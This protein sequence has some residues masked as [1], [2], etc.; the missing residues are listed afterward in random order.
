MIIAGSDAS[1]LHYGINSFFQL[2]DASSD[3]RSAA[4][5]RIIDAP[6]FP[7]RWFYYSTNIYVGNNIITAKNIWKQASDFRL[8]GVAIADSKFSRPTTLYPKYNDSLQSLKRFSADNY[9]K[10][11]P[12]IMPFGYSGGLLFHDPNLASGL[13]VRNQ[14]ILIRSEEHTSELQSH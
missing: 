9:M 8:N 1:G 14:K 12:C 2:L 5:C 6:E 7:I 3:G 4:A 13:P 10:M 11:I